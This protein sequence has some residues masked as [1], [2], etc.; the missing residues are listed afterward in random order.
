METVSC[1]WIIRCSS[2]F[3]FGCRLTLDTIF[4]S[5]RLCVFL[6]PLLWIELQGNWSHV[7]GRRT[8]NPERTSDPRNGFHQSCAEVPIY[9][10]VC[11]VE[12]GSSSWQTLSFFSRTL[13]DVK[14]WWQ[15][16]TV[17]SLR[18]L[19]YFTL[20]NHFIFFNSAK[21]VSDL[22]NFSLTFSPSIME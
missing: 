12:G 6:S 20:A 2:S 10:G 17:S 21:H 18:Y 5:L 16:L 15:M 14:H 11:P 22:S 8:S 3:W 9:E 4:L 13:I 19:G 7:R 1:R